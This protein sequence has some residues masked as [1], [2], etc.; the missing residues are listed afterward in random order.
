MTSYE[1]EP[2]NRPQAMSRILIIS[3][4]RVAMLHATTALAARLVE[5]GHSVVYA[6][7]DQVGSKVSAA[8][9]PYRQLPPNGLSDHE[10]EI[11]DLGV[12][13]LPMV[14]D[15]IEPD[16]L[17]IDIELHAHILTCMPLGVPIGLLSP[18]ISI[19]KRKG[20]PPLH[21]SVVPGRGFRG[22]APYAEW[23]WARFRVR[24]L[25][26]SWL[27]RFRSAGQDQ[28][29]LLRS[30]AATNGIQ[31]RAEITPWQW[32][33]PFSYRRLPVLSL[34]ASELDFSLDTVSGTRYCGAMIQRQ[35]PGEILSADTR[36]RLDSLYE[37]RQSGS[38]S[39][40]IVC[41]LSTFFAADPGFV[42]RMVEAVASE[43]T[44]DLVL[45]AGDSLG[46]EALGI[47]PDNV[48]A[49]AWIPQMEV[50]GHA[51]CAV[52]NA[53]TSVFECIQEGVPMVVYSLQFNDQNG[54]AA[55]IAYHGL[56]IVGDK[57]RDS[58]VTIQS[59]IRRLLRDQTHRQ[60][61]EAMRSQLATYDAEDRAVR[62]VES[63][64]A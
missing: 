45:T 36:S 26:R 64:I 51:D 63:L 20:L 2:I 60:R 50:L 21:S 30:V 42:S 9:L 40:L 47:L 16:L 32:L 38:S 22:S 5:A 3:Q 31:W 15:Q 62:A 1:L 58:G 33:I 14:V 6:S 59:H 37:N 13:D 54:T 19:V 17:L 23:L 34:T 10:P 29:S 61:V 7:P 12:S 18:F 57:D 55:R 11:E 53:G 8:G 25:L 49:F 44:W 56:G 24:K 4:G 43:P 48:H 35:R 52:I 28:V 41:S 46:V 39:A 27:N